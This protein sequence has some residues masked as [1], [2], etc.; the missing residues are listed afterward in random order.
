MTFDASPGALPESSPPRTEPA[1]NVFSSPP[2][3]PELDLSPATIGE[4]RVQ[5]AS[6]NHPSAKTT[7]R[8]AFKIA[9]APLDA[10]P[11]VHEFDTDGEGSTP[12]AGGGG[13]GSALMKSMSLG[14]HTGPVDPVAGPMIDFWMLHKDETPPVE[15]EVGPWFWRPSSTALFSESTQVPSH[16]CSVAVA[17]G[18]AFTVHLEHVAL[19][20]FEFSFT[21]HIQLCV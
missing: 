11:T 13:V 1:A 4:A 8:S 18:C 7:I 21:L 14:G 10:L 15:V 9:I 19:I 12:R 2:V 3:T 6:Q 16:G 20:T 5:P 17:V